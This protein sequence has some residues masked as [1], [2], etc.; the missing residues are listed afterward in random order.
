[1]GFFSSSNKE[2]PKIPTM[3]TLPQ[4]DS[5]GSSPSE[6]P[7]MSPYHDSG[8]LNE[9]MIKSAVVDSSVEQ[10]V[11][12]SH[13]EPTHHVSDVPVLR[14]DYKTDTTRSR[15][16]ASSTVYVKIDKFNKAQEHLAEVDSKVKS[17]SD[18]IQVLKDIKSKEIKELTMWE[19]E[20]KKI[21]SRLS[22]IDSQIFGDI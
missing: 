21:N 4:I 20:L 5:R 10:E 12:L 15:G 6:L 17:I 2:A 14:A 11:I 16:V 22:L 7:S 18:E 9:Q 8:N 3:P 1:M 19:D 13:D